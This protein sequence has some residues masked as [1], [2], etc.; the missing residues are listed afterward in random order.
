MRKRIGMATFIVFGFLLCSLITEGNCDADEEG[1]V[2]RDTG[3]TNSPGFELTIRQSG[4]TECRNN[5]WNK[6]RPIGQRG[7]KFTLPEG[8]ANLPREIAARLFADLKAGPPVSKLPVEPCLKS[9]SFGSSTYV[10]YRGETSPDIQC[11]AKGT[12]QLLDDYRAIVEILGSQAVR[13]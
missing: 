13:N 11:L 1:V 4:Q 5:D 8:V 10:V 3:S 7:G 6:Q 12:Q 9:A 2:I